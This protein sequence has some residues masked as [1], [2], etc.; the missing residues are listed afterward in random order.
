MVNYDYPIY[1]NHLVFLRDLM[2]TKHSLE[3]VKIMESIESIDKFDIEFN[4]WSSI[5]SEAKRI[6]LKK[7]SNYLEKMLVLNVIEKPMFNK[8]N[9]D[10]KILHSLQS[11]NNKNAFKHK[12]SQLLKKKILDEFSDFLGIFNIE[13]RARDFK[14]LHSD[15]ID[16]EIKEMLL[17][18]TGFDKH[19]HYVKRPESRRINE[20]MYKRKYEIRMLV[21]P[22]NEESSNRITH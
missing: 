13:N 21:L 7:K 19:G 12:F 6:G 15:E 9:Q 22:T 5:V 11:L 18:L 17:K 8:L 14:F 2:K 16:T 20:D 10:Y 4:I 1:I 3:Y